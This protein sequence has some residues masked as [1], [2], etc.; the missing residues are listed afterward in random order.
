MRLERC[1]LF[2]SIM[3]VELNC[4]PSLDR[5]KPDLMAMIFSG[6]FLNLLKKLWADSFSLLITIYLNIIDTEAATIM[7]TFCI[8]YDVIGFIID[9]KSITVFC[10]IWNQISPMFLVSNSKLLCLKLRELRSFFTDSLDFKIH[11]GFYWILC[12]KIHS[13]FT[14]VSLKILEIVC[15]DS[16]WVHSFV[17][18][19]N[20]FPQKLTILH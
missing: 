5:L 1:D 14:I 18:L 4:S 7:Y 15:R 8:T 19:R 20:S 10:E 12:I 9:N 17:F 3:S 6:K 13:W 16:E 2:E 11:I